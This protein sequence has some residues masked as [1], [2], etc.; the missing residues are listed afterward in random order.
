MELRIRIPEDRIQTELDAIFENYLE[1]CRRFA[2]LWPPCWKITVI[3]LFAVAMRKRHPFEQ[4]ACDGLAY[5][6]AVVWRD[7]CEGCDRAAAKWLRDFARAWLLREDEDKLPVFLDCCC[8]DS[9]EGSD[10]PA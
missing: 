3:R 5:L 4:N 6:S 10:A 2:T 7:N 1:E 9:S 8:E